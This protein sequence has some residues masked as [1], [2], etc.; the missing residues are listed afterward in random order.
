VS[1]NLPRR[2]KWSFTNPSNSWGGRRSRWSM[3]R[4]VRR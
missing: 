2:R 4:R 3:L 1:T